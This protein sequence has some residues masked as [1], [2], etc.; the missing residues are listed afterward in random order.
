M[1]DSGASAYGFV[2][3]IFA[4]LNN[5]MLI[6][7]NAPRSLKVFDG[8]ESS[9]GRITHL[10][11]TIILIEGHSENI[12]L[13]VTTLALFDIVLGLPW[14]QFHNPKVFWSEN[15]ILYD[16]PACREHWTYFPARTNAIDPEYVSQRKSAKIP[17]KNHRA[18]LTIEACDLKSVQESATS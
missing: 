5:L 1:I 17:D 9:A 8:T 12:L 3:T 13:F 4:H 2:D 15:T 16:H 18:P 10:A 6:P 7:L 14:L 11:K